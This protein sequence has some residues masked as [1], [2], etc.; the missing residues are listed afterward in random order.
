MTEQHHTPAV[1]ELGTLCESVVSLLEHPAAIVEDGETIIAHNQHWGRIA[2]DSLGSGKHLTLQHCLHNFTQTDLLI[3][4][5]RSNTQAVGVATLFRAPD[6]AAREEQ[7]RPY[8][9]RWRRLPPPIGQGL[10]A[11]VLARDVATAD[12]ALKLMDVQPIRINR[13]LINQTLIEEAERRKIGQALHDVVAQ[14]L[15]EIRAAIVAHGQAIADA[16]TIIATVDSVIS[17]VRTL[18]FE[19]SPPVLED[20][21]LLHALRWLV[22]HTMK[23]RSA[24]ITIADDAREPPMSS[25]TRTIVFRA[26]RELVLNAVK[27][28][29]GAEIIITC[30]SDHREARIMVRDNGPGFDTAKATPGADDNASTAYGLLSVEH[31][32]MGVGGSFELTSRP[33]E[34]TRAVIT[35]QT[36]QDGADEHA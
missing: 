29:P 35:I 32:I 16:E 8:E 28:A 4:S 13:S 25:V 31:R 33:G 1:P 27:H 10:L 26:V 11:M 17:E 23:Q 22:D 36:R 14:E 19:L 18:S 7:P 24:N 21:G 6:Q 2:G 5:L 3:E 30:V 34:G 9:F 20:L 12:R 15:G